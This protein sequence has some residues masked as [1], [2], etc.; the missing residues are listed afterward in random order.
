MP[1]P[2]IR[3]SRP[4]QRAHRLS[5]VQ[6]TVRF[7]LATAADARRLGEGHDSVDREKEVE[8]NFI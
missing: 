5:A 4:A 6:Q 3:A 8:V 1:H 7:R 2:L